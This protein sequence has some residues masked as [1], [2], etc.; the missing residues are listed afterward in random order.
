MT[1]TIPT[2]VRLRLGHAAV[3]VVAD[4]IGAD[5]L[6]IKGESL[7]PTVRRRGRSASDVD[8]LVHP[9]HVVDLLLA[10]RAAGWEL[11][12]DFPSSSAFEHSATLRHTAWG[13]LDVH[14]SFPGFTARPETVFSVLWGTRHTWQSAGRTCSVPEPTAQRL[15]LLL[16]AARSRGSHRG[17]QDIAHTW[18]DAAPDVRGDVDELARRLGAE[19]GLAAATG[20]LDQWRQHPDHDLWRVASA[21]GTRIDEWRARVKAA[22]TARGKLRLVGR[23][24]LVNVEH[25]AMIRGRPPTRREVVAEFFAR[26]ARGIRE[27]LTRR[28]GGR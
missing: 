4:R 6:H 2:A 7:D 5:V 1:T 21:G 18:T 26:P 8:V 20:R 10:L 13:H 3:Q 19:V 14:R 16:H 17:R 28:R 25:L 23:A 27:E 24:A 9:G 12:N 11:L 22:P 15:I